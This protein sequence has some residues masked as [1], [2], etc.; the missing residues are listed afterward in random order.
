MAHGDAVRTEVTNLSAIHLQRRATLGIDPK[1][2][3]VFELQSTVDPVE[4]ERADLTVLDASLQK[5]VV[6]FADDPHLAT[7]ME[8]LEGYLSDAPPGQQSQ[9]HE[10]FFDSIGT[11]RRFGSQDRLTERL[12]LRLEETAAEYELRLDIELWHP[13]GW[14]L[15]ND[16]LNEVKVAIGSGGGRVVDDYSNSGAGLLLLRAYARADLVLELAELDQ[17]ARLDVLPDPQITQEVLFQNVDEL[18]TWDPPGEDAPLVAL[19]DSGVRSAHP[20]LA[21]AIQ[22]A[23]SLSN[24]FT[25]GEDDCGH[26]TRVASLLLHGPLTSFLAAPVHGRP[27]CRLLSIKV[28]D[29][30]GEFP[31]ESLWEA[32]LEEAIR[33]AAGQGVRIVNLSIGDADTPYRGPRPTPVAALLDSLAKELELVFVVPTG[34]VPIALYG[35][36]DQALISQ[37]PAQLL[38]NSQTGLLDPAAAALAL[39]VGGLCSA[40]AAGGTLYQE[41]VVRRPFG[42][43]G[44]PSVL[45]RRGPGIASAIKP[46]TAA[47]AGS[48]AF[49]LALNRAVLDAEA[50]ILT[51]SGNVP[52]RLLEVTIGTSLAAPIVTRIAAAIVNR[53]PNFGPNLIRALVLQG[54]ATAD[55]EPTLVGGGDAA[56][57]TATRNLVGYGPARLPE[58]VESTD[59]RVVLIA[60]GRVP[61]DGIHIYEVPIP[62]SFFDP[63]GR[64]GIDIALAFDPEPEVV[65]S[66]TYHPKWT[67]IS[68]EVRRPMR[69]NPCS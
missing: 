62:A 52:E 24:E 28:L 15:A 2:I 5:A 33:Y 34:N 36:I 21:G 55:F 37:Y 29:G 23:V 11:V 47:P 69:W 17:V 58:S 42:R 54:T 51:A 68:S 19:I 50:G 63:G 45:T 38:G 35:D 56:Q 7:F 66:T 27:F 8:R 64:R 59:H 10:A 16:W 14:S 32:E 49:D 3:L 67:S 48:Q 65:V 30:D 6:A 41:T 43:A 12:L 4:F 20:L 1:L 60:E 9:P 40:S 57:K 61:V 39:T 53:Y 44:W 22:D 25:D 26:G 31:K 13:G 46:E 18:P